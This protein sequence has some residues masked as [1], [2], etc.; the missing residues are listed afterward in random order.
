M[1]LNRV[2]LLISLLVLV[3][4]SS[5][6]MAQESWTQWRGSQRTGI[7]EN[8]HWPSSLDKTNLA[9]L[10]A[11]NFGPSYS[12][13]LIVDGLVYTTETENKKWEIV[14]AIDLNTGVKRWEKKWDGAMA[15]PFYAKANGD[16]IRATPAIHKGRL[17]VAGMRDLLVCLDAKTGED[18]WNKDFVKEFKTPLPS[19]GYVSS[20]LPDG[21]FIYVQAGGGLVKLNAETGEILWRSLGDKGGT[22]GAAFSSPII[23]TLHGERQLIVQTR[24]FLAG[25]DMDSGSVL[26]KQEVP[27]FRGMNIITPCRYKSGFFVSTYGGGT[28]YFEIQKTDTGYQS[29][30]KWKTTVQGYMSTPIII[31]QYAYVHLRNQR[32]TCI[33]IETGKTQWTSTP[34]GKYWSMVSDGDRILALDETGVLYLVNANPE[35]F[36]VLSSHKLGTSNTWAHIGIANN[37]ILIRDLSQLI[38]LK[39]KKDISITSANKTN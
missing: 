27:A 13:P 4:S 26:W 9:P 24:Q 36:E 19:F 5:A 33:D 28:Y 15:V 34:F 14:T 32:V 20:P 10:W 17:Y 11:S 23:E 16:W 31:G 12:G 8:S 18:L 35:K 2:L 6:S 29:T 1:F 3:I 39:W 38:C 25:L 7:V 21:D 30:E 22:Y 37:H